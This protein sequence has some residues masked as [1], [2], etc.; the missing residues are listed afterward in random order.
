MEIRARHRCPVCGK[1]GFPTVRWVT[2]TYYPKYAS[3]ETTLAEQRERELAAK[4]NSKMLQDLVRSLKERVNGIKYKGENRKHLQGDL[5]TDED[6]K[7]FNDKKNNIRIQ[8]GGRRYYTYF[9][10]YSPEKYR[11]QMKRYEQGLRKSRPNGR[12][13]CKVPVRTDNRYGIFSDYWR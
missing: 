3:I 12:R 4:P 5:W 1:R 13:W 2:S 11:E 6:D 7:A 10:H 9:G 8:Y